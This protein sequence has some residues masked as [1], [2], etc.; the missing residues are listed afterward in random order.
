[1]RV[2]WRDVMEEMYRNYKFAKKDGHDDDEAL[3]LAMDLWPEQLREWL[4]HHSPDHIWQA[5]QDAMKSE[6]LEYLEEKDR[7][8]NEDRQL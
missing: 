3:E 6:F 1:M 8:D 4:H 7:A 5:V 2:W